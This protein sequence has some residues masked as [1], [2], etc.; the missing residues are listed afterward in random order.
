MG[1][2]QQS[3]HDGQTCSSCHNS[4]FDLVSAETTCDELTTLICR[5]VVACTGVCGICGSYLELYETCR[6]GSDCF[7]TCSDSAPT[8]PIAPSPAPAPTAAG[9]AADQSG[10]A[11]QD[12]LDTFGECIASTGNVTLC[13]ECLEA[14]LGP[15]AIVPCD[16]ILAETCESQA[17]CPECGTCQDE[18]VAYANC[19]NERLC[20]T[21]HSSVHQQVPEPP[22]PSVT[23]VMMMGRPHL[24]PRRRLP[25]PPRV[26]EAERKETHPRSR[27]RAQQRRGAVGA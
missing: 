20:D 3:N 25:A 19:R 11:C 15:P 24:L 16:Q 1:C 27:R 23:V 4:Y 14:H 18:Q 9:P 5:Y 17:A 26:R 8:S 2:I 12:E 6:W 13:G 7:G 21:T 10:P 22:T